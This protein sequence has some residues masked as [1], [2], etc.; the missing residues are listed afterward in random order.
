MK[1]KIFALFMIVACLLTGCGK[2]AKISEEVKTLMEDKS[3][4]NLRVAFLGTATDLNPI[5]HKDSEFSVMIGYF[6]HG[7]PLRKTF[8]GGYTTCLFKNYNLTV[9]ESGHLVIEGEW[10]DD[11]KWHD[12]VKFDSA[13]LA[14]TFR[15]IAEKSNKSP[16]YD[17]VK[18]VIRVTN[19]DN[20]CQIVCKNDSKRFL[21]LLTVGLMPS[22]I[23]ERKLDNKSNIEIETLQKE[24]LNQNYDLSPVGLGPY[25]IVKREAG[26]YTILEPFKDF[27]DDYVSKRCEKILFRSS[28]D[29]D[30][31][32]SEIKDNKYDWVSIPTPIYEHLKS[33][34]VEEVQA[35]G[36][37][38]NSCV[39]WLFNTSKPEL[40]D[41]NIRKAL[42]LLVNRNELLNDN[43]VS[44]NKLYASPLSQNNNIEPQN[45]K[46]I[47]LESLQKAGISEQNKL[48]IKI[49][50][51]DISLSI[52]SMADK[53][54]NDLKQ[55]NIVVEVENVSWGEFVTKRLKTKDYITA[56]AVLYLPV[57]GNWVNIV[58]TDEI[59]YDKLNFTGT[60][61]S[62]IDTILKNLDSVT[63][64]GDKKEHISLL[65]NYLDNEM[66]M[67]FLIKPYDVSVRKGKSGIT[68]KNNTLPEEV[69]SW[70]VLY[71]KEQ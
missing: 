59:A 9:D 16:Y 4:R 2:K 6:I 55:Y 27:R 23:L 12:G 14:Y 18:D 22:H 64:K 13:D 1:I 54:A 11:I 63:Y 24:S 68:F 71:E 32:L 50:V 34:G 36:Y 48:H 30:T 44:G 3:G 57:D 25:K 15:K 31:L 43:G 8:D 49:L 40:K 28:Y 20:K 10:K 19:I 46:Q 52:K 29:P 39:T 56:L 65:A 70:S 5:Y 53:I 45:S 37:I 42:N 58:G 61:N 62:E 41:V 60:G 7:A 67:A 38:N 17:I 26:I 66:P 51:S 33:M 69:L 21:D 47:A 35:T